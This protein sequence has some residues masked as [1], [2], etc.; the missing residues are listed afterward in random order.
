M[1]A[2]SIYSE[3]AERA[4]RLF[5]E[6]L[7]AGGASFGSGDSQAPLHALYYLHLARARIEAGLR[8][9]AA[10]ALEKARRLHPPI[11]S[12]EEYLRLAPLVR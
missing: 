9:E 8:V 4:V 10:E 6:R 7:A 11:A 5:E 1:T 3:A 2:T 12:D